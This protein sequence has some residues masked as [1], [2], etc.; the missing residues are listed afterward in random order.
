MCA[1]VNDAVP[2]ET[3]TICLHAGAM[4]ERGMEFIFRLAR[5][6]AKTDETPAQPSGEPADMWRKCLWWHGQLGW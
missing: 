1:C 5:V 2:F 6:T 4:A 3:S